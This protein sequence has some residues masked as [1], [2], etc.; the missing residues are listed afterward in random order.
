MKC[1]VL[2]YN[3]LMVDIDAVPCCSRRSHD[4]ACMFVGPMR[5]SNSHRKPPRNEQRIRE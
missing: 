5:D 4:C 1:F 2:L 3:E